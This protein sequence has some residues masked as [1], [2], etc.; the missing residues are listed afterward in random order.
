MSSATTT[1][2]ATCCGRSCP[3]PTWSAS[4]PTPA[5]TPR[6]RVP[7][8]PIGSSSSGTWRPA[9][10]RSAS[11]ATSRTRQR[12]ELRRL[13]PVRVRRQRR[14]AGLPRVQPLSVRRHHRGRPRARCRRTHPPSPHHRRRRRHRQPPLPGGRRLR[15]P[16]AVDRSAGGGPS[17]PRAGQPLPRQ[18][19]HRVAEAAHG[20]IDGAAFQELLFAVS[21]AVVN[22]HLHGR[23]PIT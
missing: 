10:S 23:R 11:P 3:G 6:L 5:C 2:S 21:E 15:A 12:R 18:T 17:D 4:S 1:A 22:A 14:L 8:R 7:S 9:L 19:R 16:A 13:G 20:R